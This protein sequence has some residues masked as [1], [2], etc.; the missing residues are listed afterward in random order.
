MMEEQLKRIA[1]SLET[2]KNLMLA[3]HMEERKDRNE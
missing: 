1:D 3:Q 2:I